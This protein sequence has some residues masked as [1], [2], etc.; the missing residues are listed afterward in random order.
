MEERTYVSRNGADAQ[1]LVLNLKGRGQE[2]CTSGQ[3]LSV[4]ITGSS[5]AAPFDQP[6]QGSFAFVPLMVA[7]ATD[8]R[9]DS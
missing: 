9:S 8:L 4:H 2:L 3:P 5:A 1:E 6:C 7:P